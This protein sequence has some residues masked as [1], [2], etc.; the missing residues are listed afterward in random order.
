M[1]GAMDALYYGPELAATVCVCVCVC[2]CARVRVC[3][4]AYAAAACNIL[5]RHEWPECETK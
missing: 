2:V 1:V 4:R 3:V 5:L